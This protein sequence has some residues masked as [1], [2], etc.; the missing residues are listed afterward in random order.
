[1]AYLGAIYV[2]KSENMPSGNVE[3]ACSAILDFIVCL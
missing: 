1:M 2:S 3:D